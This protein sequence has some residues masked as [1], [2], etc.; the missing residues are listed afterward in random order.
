M[1]KRKRRLI[2]QAL[3]YLEII[4]TKKNQPLVNL[5]RGILYELLDNE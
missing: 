5:V 3:N 4:E 1:D 2:F